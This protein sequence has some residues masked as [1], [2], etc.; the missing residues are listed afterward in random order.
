MLAVLGALAA[1][2]LITILKFIGAFLT[3]SSEVMAEGFH[4][5]ADTTNQV[6]LLLGLRFYKKPASENPRSVTVKNDFFGRL[7]P[8]FSSSASAQ[9]MPF[10]KASKKSSIRTRLPICRGRIGFWEFLSCWKPVQS[11]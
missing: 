4:S 8:R 10:T 6:F 1:N 9:P 7:S 2:G 3:G 5:L 11:A